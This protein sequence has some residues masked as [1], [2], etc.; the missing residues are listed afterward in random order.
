[1]LYL[2]HLLLDP[3]G[4][5]VEHCQNERADGVNT[6]GD[7]DFR[8][9]GRILINLVQR[10]GHETAGDHAEG[11]VDPGACDNRHTCHGQSGFIFTGDRIDGEDDTD[12]HQG[13]RRPH[14]GHHGVV[15]MQP[16]EQV[17]DVIHVFGDVAVEGD[18]HLTEEE[19]Y[20]DADGIGHGFAEALNLGLARVEL[21]GVADEEAEQHQQCRTGGKG[22]TQKARARI[23]VNQKPR[24][25]RPQ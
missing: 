24:P 23:A 6:Q 1:M 4:H 5:L 2:L 8:D 21:G 16:D 12:H 10:V 11:F 14:P 20:I 22:R 18:E 25:G 19:E 13:H 7:D 9:G 3:Y 17:L 15:T